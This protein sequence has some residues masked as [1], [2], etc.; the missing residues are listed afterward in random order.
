MEKNC[1]QKL[2]PNWWKLNG[3]RKPTV[4]NATK[5]GVHMGKG[6]LLP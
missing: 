1:N 4:E 2:H 3:I 5:N 6:K